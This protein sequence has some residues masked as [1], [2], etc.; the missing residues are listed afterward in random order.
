MCKLIFFALFALAI[1]S[2]AICECPKTCDPTT[3]ATPGNCL[4]G[5][6]KDK[7]NC[8]FECGALEGQRCYTTRIRSH[9]NYTNCGNHM[10][11]NVRTDLERGDKPEAICQCISDEAICG[12]DGETYRNLC[13]INE[14]RYKRRDGLVAVSHGP[15][16]Y[17]PVI[18]SPPADVKNKTGSFVAFSCE[19]SGWPVPSIE[20]RFVSKGAKSGEV[21]FLPGDDQHFAVQ[22]RGGPGSYEKTSWLQIVQVTAAH[23]GVYIC[24]A[25]NEVGEQSG[26]ANLTL[27]DISHIKNNYI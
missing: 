15:C 3:C 4:A 25:T 21:T 13:H 6:V 2:I 23:Q 7:C 14:A 1:I 26:S 22:S 10:K 16:K 27:T 9:A 12:S 8:C 20:W 17:A 24:V 11:C 19:V 18:V 5:L